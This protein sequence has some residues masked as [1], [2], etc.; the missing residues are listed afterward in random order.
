MLI[1]D[2]FINGEIRAEEV[3]L[4][5][6]DGEQLGI[7]PLDEALDRAFDQDLDLVN[8]APNA[9][10]PVTRI[11]DY[12]K[13]RYEME[14][15]EQE[16]R[17]NQRSIE[18]KEVRMSMHIEEHDLQVKANQ[19]IRFLKNGDKVKVSVRFRG[20][21]LGHKDQGREVLDDFFELVKEYGEIDKSPAM[22]GRSMVMFLVA[23]TEE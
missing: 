18:L 14:K 11:M 23:R 3:R 2:L 10:P 6:V 16:A 8:V 21:E 19:A 17:R 7:V 1:K 9:K 13:Y 5:D 22:E 20:R 15:K 12:G 4:I